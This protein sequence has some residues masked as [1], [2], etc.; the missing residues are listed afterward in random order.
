MMLPRRP[1]K[2]RR[3]E[4]WKLRKDDTQLR[5]SDTPKICGICRQLGNKRNSC[6]QAPQTQHQSRQPITHST[7]TPTAT[8]IITHKLPCKKGQFQNDEILFMYIFRLPV[9]F[10]FQMYL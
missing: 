2:K 8:P 9:Y 1:K 7:T 6:P 5:Q 4:S 10:G 3:L